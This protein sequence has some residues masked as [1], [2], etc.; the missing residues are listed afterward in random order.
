[1]QATHLG[2]EHLRLPAKHRRV[3]LRH[4][5]SILSRKLEVYNGIHAVISSIGFLHYPNATAAGA[6]KSRYRDN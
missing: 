4:T 3:E 2:A 6:L 1:M 5:I